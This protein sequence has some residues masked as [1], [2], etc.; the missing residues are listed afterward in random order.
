MSSAS[1][2]QNQSMSYRGMSLV[3]SF[4][5]SSAS[6][7]TPPNPHQTSKTPIPKPS[8]GGHSSTS[9]LPSRS[10]PIETTTNLKTSKTHQKPKTTAKPK[11]KTPTKPRQQHPSSSVATKKSYTKPALPPFIPNIMPMGAMHDPIPTHLHT[12]PSPAVRPLPPLSIQPLAIIYPI[13]AG[14]SQPLP[15]RAIIISSPGLPHT[16]SGTPPIT[17]P[18]PSSDSPVSE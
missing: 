1:N 14:A 6:M 2:S 7:S 5:S 8:H 11:P 9:Q 17:P 13:E 15:L 10:K 18:R 3:S 4:S 16:P 12:A